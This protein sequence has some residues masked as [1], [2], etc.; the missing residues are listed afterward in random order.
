MSFMQPALRSLGSSVMEGNKAKAQT[1]AQGL[2]EELHC[3][4]FCCDKEI[5]VH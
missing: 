5:N 1:G 3:A 4:V 2:Y